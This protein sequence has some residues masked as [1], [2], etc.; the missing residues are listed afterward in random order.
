MEY[1]C[2]KCKSEVP[3]KVHDYLKKFGRVLMP[4]LSKKFFSKNQNNKKRFKRKKEEPN[5]LSKTR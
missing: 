4:R 5:G 1:H 3:K 2:E